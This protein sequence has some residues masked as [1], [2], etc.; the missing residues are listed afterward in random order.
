MPRIA[1]IS[2][3]QQAIVKYIREHG[4][5]QVEALAESFKVTPQTIRRDLNHLYDPGTGAA[6]AWWCNCKR[7]C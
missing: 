4:T 2:R 5:A 1:E 7:H 3:R 6:G